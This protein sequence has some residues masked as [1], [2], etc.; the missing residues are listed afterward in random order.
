MLY[1]KLYKLNTDGSTQV[2]EMHYDDE[3]RWTV[4]GKLDG[5]MTV[6]KPT[7]VKPKQ[8]RTMAEQ[9]A[10]ECESKVKSKRD[11]RYVDSMDDMAGAEDA[12]PGYSVM[13]AHKYIEQK[14]KIVYPC[15]GQ[16]KLDGIRCPAT[17]ADGLVSRTR[18]PFSSCQHIVKA[19]IPLFKSDPV[20]R[21]DAELY[22]HEYKDD[23][24]VIVHAVKKTAAKATEEDLELQRKVKYHVYDMPRCATLAEDVPFIDRYRYLQTLV[25][26]MDNVVL[27]ETVILEDEAEMMK[28]KEKW[29]AEGY[30]GIMLRNLASPYEGKRSFHLQKFKDFIDDEWTIVG[31]KEGE[32]KL[33]GHAGSFTFPKDRDDTQGMLDGTTAIT[34]DNSFDA[35]LIGPTPRLKDLF[36]NQ[37]KFMGKEATVRYQRFTAYGTPKFPTCRGIRDYE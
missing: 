16:P 5:K 23:F 27:V 25:K 37:D 36:E 26:D 21:L 24:E 14:A 20:L 1:K 28:Y 15:A 29:T 30:E 31:V 13:L 18:K 8:K 32:G 34:D 3:S 7:A 9:V 6:G 12:L 17:E 11:K 35:K 22:A 2:W 19:L 10:A 4:S 33:T